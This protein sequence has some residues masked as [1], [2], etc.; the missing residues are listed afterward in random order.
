MYIKAK[1]LDS[2]QYFFDLCRTMPN[3]GNNAEGVNKWRKQSKG[4]I[5]RMEE[6]DFFLANYFL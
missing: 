3:T 1:E 6:I 4:R 5:G 2:I